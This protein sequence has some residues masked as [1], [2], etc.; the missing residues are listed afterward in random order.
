M[1]PP[2]LAA[3]T[4]TP[5][6]GLTAPAYEVGGIVPIARDTRFLYPL[7]RSQQVEQGDMAI[8]EF[9]QVGERKVS[10]AIERDPVATTEKAKLALSLEL[11]TPPQAARDLRGHVPSKLFDAVSGLGDARRDRTCRSGPAALLLDWLR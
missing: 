9:K 3:T 6:S 11:A 8:Q 1:V 2:A 10:G 5:S 4:I 7:L